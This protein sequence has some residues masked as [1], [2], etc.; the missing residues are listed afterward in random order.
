MAGAALGRPLAVA[1]SA[2]GLV[3]YP[4][5]KLDKKKKKKKKKKKNA[6]GR[7]RRCSR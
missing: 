5:T 2:A 4:A 7:S 1:R 3:L 6:V